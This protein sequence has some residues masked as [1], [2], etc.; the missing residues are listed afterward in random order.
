VKTGHQIQRPEEFRFAQ[1]SKD[2][3]APRKSCPIVEN[4]KV[5]HERLRGEYASFRG[6]DYYAG[7][8]GHD[9]FESSITDTD[10][11][12]ISGIPSTEWYRF[13]ITSNSM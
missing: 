4:D 1:F 3:F 8:Y 12:P 7:H 11:S 2:I 13:I 10:A 5:G 9:I 6:Y